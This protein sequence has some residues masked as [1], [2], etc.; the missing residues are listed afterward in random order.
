MEVSIY[1]VRSLPWGFRKVG[2]CLISCCLSSAPSP[3]PTAQAQ[4]RWGR[5]LF[6]GRARGDHLGSEEAAQQPGAMASQSTT[7]TTT[8]PA[9]GEEKPPT[10]TPAPPAAAGLQ[11]PMR[12]DQVQNAINFLSH[13]KVRGSPVIYRRSFL[14]KKGLT[15][16][17]IDEAFRRVPFPVYVR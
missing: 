11:Q 7:P 13:P 15:R 4:R 9:A 14:E 3:P 10:E 17:E 8:N 12:E 2:V 6:P 16:E 1:F 5:R